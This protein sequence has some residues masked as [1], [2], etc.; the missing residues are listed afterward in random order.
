[1]TEQDWNFPDGRFLSYVLGPLREGHSPLYVVL[2]AASDAI[3]FKLPSFPEYSRW[4]AVL[5]TAVEAQLR[6][7][8]AAGTKSQAPARSVLAFSGSP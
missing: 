1:M 4:T 3:D 7:E 5:N 8:F 2:N 6:Q